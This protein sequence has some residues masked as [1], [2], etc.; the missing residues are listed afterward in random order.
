MNMTMATEFLKRCFSPEETIAILL[1]REEPGRIMQRIVRREQAT[2]PGY[3]RWLA[4]ENASGMNVYVAAN[5]L[6]SGSRKRTKECIA[7]IRNLYLDI[8]HDGDA[9]VAALRASDAV[10]EPNAIISTSLGKYQVLWRVRDFD[11]ALQEL[12]LKLLAIA[13]GGDPACTDCN[14]VIRVPRFHNNKY[15]PAHPVA[16]EYLSD[17]TVQP[18]NFRLADGLS[19]PVLPLRGNARPTA[20]GKNPHSEQDWAW[21]LTELTNGKDAAQLTQSLATRRS[22][23]PNS[24]YYAQRTVDMASARL[25]LLAGT[26]IH[27]VITSL[28]AR[29]S[30]ELPGDCSNSGTND[31]TPTARLISLT[32]ENTNAPTRSRPN[33]SDQR[34]YPALRHDRNPGRS[35]CRVHPRLRR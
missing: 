13:F 10:P 21:A 15:M 8:D 17:S 4:Q 12:T 29:R 24:L 32:K 20:T 3:L 1:R 30:A 34:L 7:V 19:E 14:R 27:D 11:F 6:R 22:D 33:P 31:C 5:P 35:I 16:V 9:R 26:S 23:K 18:E 28:E 25:A 2:G